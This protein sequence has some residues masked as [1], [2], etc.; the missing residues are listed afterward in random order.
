[1]EGGLLPLLEG[2]GDK[3]YAERKDQSLKGAIIARELTH[4]GF[5]ELLEQVGLLV[6]RDTA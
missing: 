5:F 4:A 6:E 1:L 3:P 2:Q